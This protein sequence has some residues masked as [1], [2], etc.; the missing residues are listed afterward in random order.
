MHCTGDSTPSQATPDAPLTRRLGV[1]K[2]VVRPALQPRSRRDASGLAR[3]AAPLHITTHI[4][5]PR[6]LYGLTHLLG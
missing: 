2:I 6:R 5:T 4:A 1:A 3:N